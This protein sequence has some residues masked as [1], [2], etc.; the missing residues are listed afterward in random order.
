MPYGILVILFGSLSGYMYLGM[1]RTVE[2]KAEHRAARSSASVYGPLC[3]HLWGFSTIWVG[4][5]STNCFRVL[6]R[7]QSSVPTAVVNANV[8]SSG[9]RQQLTLTGAFANFMGL[10]RRCIGIPRGSSRDSYFRVV[11]GCSEARKDAFSPLS[12]R[13]LGCVPWGPCDSLGPPGTDTRDR[14]PGRNS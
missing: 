10:N 6:C 1:D 3:R 12:A 7:G 9:L 11:F 2:F 13:L 4:F 14:Y 5:G 8:N